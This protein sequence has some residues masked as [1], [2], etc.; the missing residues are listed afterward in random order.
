[1]A[2]IV[3]S[4]SNQL[5]ASAALCILLNWVCL[6]RLAAED[7]TE[8]HRTTLLEVI[9]NIK[10]EWEDV[11][12]EV[13]GRAQEKGIGTNSP[14]A[15]DP[16]V[17][18]YTSDTLF[19]SRFR[20]S[21]EAYCRYEFTNTNSVWEYGWDGTNSRVVHWKNQQPKSASQTCHPFEPP[22]PMTDDAFAGVKIAL[23]LH[24]DLAMSLPIQG[25]GLLD[26][27]VLSADTIAQKNIAGS[28]VLE[29]VT[30]HAGYRHVAQFR[31]QPMLHCTM[32][33]REGL[34]AD[35]LTFRCATEF[36]SVR[37]HWLPKR[38]VRS[39]TS[40][41]NEGSE[42]VVVQIATYKSWKFDQQ[43]DGE[44]DFLP[45]VPDSVTLVDECEPSAESTLAQPVP[46]SDWS[47]L[48]W[49][50]LILG[51]LTLIGAYVAWSKRVLR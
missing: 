26:S 2:R 9:R 24:E 1:M 46:T 29:L 42:P 38:S 44:G 36:G 20:R 21:G 23:N 50:G 49:G 14:F 35:S 15:P 47:Y 41:T 18:A 5:I 11:T 8:Q 33:Q 13:A 7:N 34:G 48:R 22:F 16:E 27:L 19:L 25:E 28:D 31:A 17:R 45:A 10:S 39:V 30:E 4:H 43:V 3:K 51:A 40:K 32:Y 37:N 12:I 6:P